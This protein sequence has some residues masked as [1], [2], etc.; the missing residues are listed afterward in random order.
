MDT[1]D[2]VKNVFHRNL[3]LRAGVNASA[4]YSSLRKTQDSIQERNVEAVFAMFNDTEFFRSV[5]NEEKSI[6]YRYKNDGK[7]RILDRFDLEN[8]IYEEPTEIPEWT[9]TDS[10]ET[11]NGYDCILAK[12]DF[13][14]RHWTAWFT[15][16]IP[17]NEGPWKLWGLPGLI[18]K[19]QDS[20]KH[21]TYEAK[22]V[23]LNPGGYVEYFD[24]LPDRL[25]TERKKAL[26]EKRKALQKS[27][28]D[29]LIAT[30][31]LKIDPLK[32]D[33]PK[34]VDELRNYDFEET[35]YLHE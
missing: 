4:F 27:I 34:G 2:V 23:I 29:Q 14:G 32:G 12:T 8:W 30:G 25:K 16:E 5:S 24:Y 17:V 15:P 31:V 35:D 1:V 20:K 22:S 11:V 33:R 19:A 9:I 18:L 10:I 6:I 13:R 21:Y 28:R 3:T 7:T 26:Q